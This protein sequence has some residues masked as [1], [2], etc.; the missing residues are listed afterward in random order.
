MSGINEICIKIKYLTSECIVQLAIVQFMCSP[1][2]W[3]RCLRGPGMT[4]SGRDSRTIIIHKVDHQEQKHDC[5]A[6]H[7]PTNLSLSDILEQIR[8]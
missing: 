4:P 2:N 5:S 7:A 1:S 6:P 3:Q 8:K